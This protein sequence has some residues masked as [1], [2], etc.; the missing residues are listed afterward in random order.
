MNINISSISMHW[1]YQFAGAI[2]LALACMLPNQGKSQCGTPDY[3]TVI[4]SNSD[5]IVH[6]NFQY[7]TSTSSV[8]RTVDFFVPPLAGHNEKPLVVILHGGL[9]DSNNGHK[10]ETAYVNASMHLARCGYIVANMNYRTFFCGQLICSGGNCPS[11][12]DCLPNGICSTLSLQNS[13][14]GTNSAD[15]AWYKALQD[16]NA[17]IKFSVGRIERDLEITICNVLVMGREAGGITAMMGAFADQ[18]EI[19]TYNPTLSA[20][21]GSLN[22]FVK[23]NFINQPYTIKAVAAEAAALPSLD[24]LD[25]SND[26]HLIMF[27]GTCDKVIPICEPNCNPTPLVNLQGP[28]KIRDYIFTNAVVDAQICYHFEIFR[29]FGHDLSNKEAYNFLKTKEFFADVVKNTETCDVY[30]PC[31]AGIVPDCSLGDQCNCDIE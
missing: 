29:D 28:F 7:S 15:I 26:K 12:R 25:N 3:K 10:D 14:I 17:A 19:D 5:I 13:I 20:Q 24:F 18:S 22:A 23:P 30:A 9:F 16:L 21:L 4:H 1:F 31:P 2:F 8:N 27:H 6:E 11:N